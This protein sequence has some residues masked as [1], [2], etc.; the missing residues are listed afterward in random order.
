MSK[1]LVIVFL[2]IS[3]QL[4]N[5]QSFN[6]KDTIVV[7]KSDFKDINSINWS[8]DSKKL[9]LSAT[10]N[11]DDQFDIFVYNLSD[12]T[13]K[14][15]SSSKINELNPV[16]HPDGVRLIYDK[17]IDS[18]TKIFVYN[19]LTG[20]DKP[21]FNRNIQSRQGSFSSDTMLVCFSGFDI[22][23]DNWQIYTYDFVYDN[24]NQ[25]T[26]SEFNSK[27]P[28]FSPNGKHIIYEEVDSFSKSVLKMINWYGKP[29]LSIDTVD[30]SNAFWDNDSWRFNYTSKTSKGQEFFSLRYNGQAPVKFDTS[31]LN[32]TNF[33]ISPDK[34]SY[35][36]LLG[37]TDYD[38][39]II[40]GLNW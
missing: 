7:Y 27:K 3:V 31:H 29:E 34:L 20:M 36:M 1:K 5:A 25:L 33:I 23:A 12:S 6:I 35:A 26:K 37:G 28:V 4:L 39:L 14:N 13:L 38:Y 32:I 19:P 9:V 8:P 15:V 21:L 11:G 24:L 18:T 17:V 10:K 30:A 2:V 16:W 40:G 22:V